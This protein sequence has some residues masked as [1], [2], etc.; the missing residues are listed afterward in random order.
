MAEEPLSPHPEAYPIPTQ[1][2]TRDNFSIPTPFSSD[3]GAPASGRPWKNMENRPACPGG[4]NCPSMTDLQRTVLSQEEL[5]EEKAGYPPQRLRPED[6]VPQGSRGNGCNHHHHTAPSS[7]ESSTSSREQLSYSSSS[8]SSSS[9]TRQANHKNRPGRWKTP[10]PQPARAE[11][12][13]PPPPRPLVSSV[14]NPDP[15]MQYLPLPPPAPISDGQHQASAADYK[16]Q[17][18]QHRWYERE[19]VRLEEEQERKKREQERKLGQIRGPSGLVAPGNQPHGPPP[20][21]Q[22]HYQHQSPRPPHP[23][24]ALPWGAPPPPQETVIHDFLPQQQPHTVERRDLRYV[25]LDTEEPSSDS[26]SPDPWKRDA[27]EQLEKRQRLQVVDLLDGEIRELR[28]KAGRTTEENERMRR[29]Q[30]EWQFQQ[31]LQESKRSEDDEDEE[32][33]EDDEDVKEVTMMAKQQ[34]AENR[35]RQSAAPAISVLDLGS[36]VPDDP[37]VHPQLTSKSR[38]WPGGHR[39]HLGLPVALSGVSLGSGSLGPRQLARSLGDRPLLS[40]RAI[41]PDLLSHCK[42]PSSAARVVPPLL[43]KA[44]GGLGLAGEVV[45]DEK[46]VPAAGGSTPPEYGLVLQA[47]AEPRTPSPLVS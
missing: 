10:H 42:G 37:A 7:L 35:V 2:Y 20:P 11:L 33:V 3:V 9:K 16:R 30:L 12:P 14:G 19:K 21:S 44:G 15:P 17:E 34:E 29:L 39:C 26:L 40:L 25:T 45:S 4:V 24:S 1:T 32:E 43:L 18:E 27:R 41:N 5:H 23:P 47:R 22:P 36:Q 46:A 28:D 13:S 6:P 8:S 38:T 31:R